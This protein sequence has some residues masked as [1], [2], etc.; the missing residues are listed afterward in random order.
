V[1]S[2]AAAALGRLDAF[3]ESSG[4]DGL[5]VFESHPIQ[6]TVRVLFQLNAPQTTILQ[7]WSELQ[8]RLVLAQPRLIYFQ[9]RNPLQAVKQ[10]ARMRG[11]AWES[12]LIET[13]QQSP[14]MRARALSGVEGADQ[15]L[16]EYADLIDQLADLWRFPM[17]TLPA[18]PEN[19]DARTDAL[20]KWAVAPVT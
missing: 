20:T 3:L 18:R 17:L 15:M 7:F 11:P 9:E 1:D 8:D 6:S 10:I 2:F 14:W 4:S 12:Y 13:F 16:V 19:Y 5:Y